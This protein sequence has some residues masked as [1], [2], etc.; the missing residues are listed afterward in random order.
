MYRYCD[1]GHDKAKDLRSGQGGGLGKRG[2][3]EKVRSAHLT[4]RGYLPKPQTKKTHI[5]ERLNQQTSRETS[6]LVPINFQESL[7]KL[8]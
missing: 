7:R 6:D 1:I 8:I 5:E 2:K 4:L 3:T